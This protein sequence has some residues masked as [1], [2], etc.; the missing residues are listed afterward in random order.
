MAKGLGEQIDVVWRRGILNGRIFAIGVAKGAVVNRVF[1]TAE[2][3][4][5]DADSRASQRL[6]GPWIASRRFRAA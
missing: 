4:R 1:R 5:R 3:L 2:L 6:D